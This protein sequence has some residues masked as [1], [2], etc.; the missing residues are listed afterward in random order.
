MLPAISI[1]TRSRS[2]RPGKL[3]DEWGDEPVEFGDLVAEV[4]R[5]PGERFQRDFGYRG[6]VAERE[7]VRPPRGAGPEQAACG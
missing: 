4:E 1:P 5:S 3:S 7:R 6:W 2:G